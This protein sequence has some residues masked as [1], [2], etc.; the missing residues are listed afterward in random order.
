[1]LL[2]FKL[3]FPLVLVTIFCCCCCFN[4]GDLY[5]W[6]DSPY[7]SNGVFW[8]VLMN[9]LGSDCKVNPLNTTQG[10][11]NMTKATSDVSVP[12]NLASGLWVQSGALGLSGTPAELSGLNSR[13]HTPS[14]D[15]FMGL[16]HQTRIISQ[17]LG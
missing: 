9:Q 10:G 13:K 4:P 7:L 5:H 16:F 6:E 8:D 17:F 3:V 15:Y 11:L 1:M 14:L 2:F 12:N